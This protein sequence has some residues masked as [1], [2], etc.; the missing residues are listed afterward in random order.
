MRLTVFL[1]ALLLCVHS[2]NAAHA[3]G[4]RQL[5]REAV[6]ATTAKIENI[7][8]KGKSLLVT[9]L[10]IITA[11][12][13]FYACDRVQQVLAPVSSQPDALMQVED[14]GHIWVVDQNGVEVPVIGTWELVE[15]TNPNSP[16]PIGDRF[17]LPPETPH[18]TLLSEGTY[19]DDTGI[20]WTKANITTADDLHLVFLERVDTSTYPHQ[21]HI[22]WKITDDHQLLPAYGEYP[23]ETSEHDVQI[24]E[25]Q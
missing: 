16:F 2:F 14:R 13:N 3:G 12:V 23:F 7:S 19:T 10:V 17:I 18:K 20:D 6:R 22:V 5:A 24:W 11:C 21:L 9:P 4:I 25:K 15:Q 1:L 8:N